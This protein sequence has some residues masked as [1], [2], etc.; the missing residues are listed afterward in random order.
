MRIGPLI[1]SLLPG[2]VERTASRAYRRVF[3]NLDKVARVL[4]ENLPP[5]ACVLDVGGGDGDLL[6][7]LLLLRPDLRIDMVD[8]APRVGGHLHAN[9]RDR[10][11]FFPGRRLES[12]AHPDGGTYDAIMIADVMHHIPATER[13]DFLASLRNGLG[14]RAVIL[15]KDVEPGHPIAWLGLYCDR[16]L[17]GDRDTQLIASRHLQSMMQAVWP[18]HLVREQGLLGLNRPNYLIGAIPKPA[19][20]V[21][22]RT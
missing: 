2:W 16:Y 3:V 17:S 1:R 10:V 11:R 6:N 9:H 12:H 5:H 13:A 20:E 8:I 14:R 22:R 19:H 18:D 4:G 15:I 21:V 7:R